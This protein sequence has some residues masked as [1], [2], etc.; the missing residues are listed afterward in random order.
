MSY[1]DE[2]EMEEIAEGEVKVQTDGV[3]ATVNLG[4]SAIESIANGLTYRLENALARKIEKAIGEKL[5]AMID[6]AVTKVIG[7]RAEALV[8]EAIEKPRQKTNEWGSPTGPVVTLAE[9][10]PGI[11]D[12]Y[13]NAKV[14]DKGQVDSYSRDSKV[15]RAGFIIATMVREHIDPVTTQA[16]SNIT[17]QARD[18]VAQKI[19]AFVSEQMVPAI[20]VKRS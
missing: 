8:R 4:N 6:E 10:I 18:I 9:L 14:N 15:T 3:T 5:D 7:D 12:N 1:F 17:K 16:V 2:D 19:A 20:E 13:L 11:V